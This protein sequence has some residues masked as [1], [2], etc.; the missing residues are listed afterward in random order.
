MGVNRNKFSIKRVFEQ[1]Q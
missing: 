1:V